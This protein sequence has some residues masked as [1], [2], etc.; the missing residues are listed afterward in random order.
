MNISVIQSDIAWLDRERNLESFEKLLAPLAGSTDLAVLPEM[1]TSG[2]TTDPRAIAEKPGGQTYRWMERTAAEFG[3]A[4]CGSFVVKEG[5][6]FYNRFLFMGPGGYSYSYDKRHLF[7]M[8]GEDR[9]FSAGTKRV[10]FDY[11]GFRI[12][13]CIC[14]DLR[15]PVWMRNRNDYDLLIVSANWPETRIDVWN[16][17][18]KARAIENQ[19]YVAGSNRTG[20][21]GEGIKYNGHSWVFGPKGE[22]LAA[23]G[24][25]LSGV[26]SAD[27]D[28][29]QLEQFR[30]KFPAWKDADGFSLNV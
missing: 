8:G 13:P 6:A 14:Y 2:F 22:E 28:I 15:F 21:D 18:L 29:K 12:S 16:T 1:F 24:T 7:S 17:L 4:I 5:Q 3:F 9:Y 26:I 30:D 23:A 19:C 10:V 25:V 20:S 11:M 27:I